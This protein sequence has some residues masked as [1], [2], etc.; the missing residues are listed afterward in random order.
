MAGE[1]AWPAADRRPAVRT[2]PPRSR[3]HRSRGCRPGKRHASR[4]TPPIVTLALDTGATRARLRDRRLARPR[5]G[6]GRRRSRV[7]GPPDHLRR[8][9][10][11]ALAVR[12]RRS[13]GDAAVRPSWAVAWALAS[14]S[15]LAVLRE[16]AGFTVKMPADPT[17]GPPDS[18]WV[19]PARS[20]QVALIWAASDR[21]PATQEPGVGLV[22]TAFHG[23]S[24]SLVHQGPSGHGNDVRTGAGR[25][26]AR[27]S[28]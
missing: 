23:G 27:V 18:A 28:G 2:S 19:N 12:G 10:P 13:V 26:Q 4:R 1:V 22:L 3:A 7:A 24:T 25:R 17:I 16:R 5:R 15:S 6:R 14:R 8:A 21:L 20:D 9:V 11:G